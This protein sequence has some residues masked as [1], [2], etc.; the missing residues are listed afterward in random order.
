MNPDS[1]QVRTDISFY[2]LLELLGR[3][4][5]R[6]YALIKTVSNP[7]LALATLLDSNNQNPAFG[8]GES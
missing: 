6:V 2:Q 8:I 1:R 7:C 5:V 4:P 3:E